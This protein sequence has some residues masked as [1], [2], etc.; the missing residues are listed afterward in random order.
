MEANLRTDLRTRLAMDG[1][2]PFRPLPRITAE[3]LISEV[4]RSAEPAE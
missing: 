2:E 3:S 1:D 4:I